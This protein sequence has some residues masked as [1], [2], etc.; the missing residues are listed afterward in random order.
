VLILDHREIVTAAHGA[1]QQINAFLD[2]ALDAAKL[3]AAVDPSLYRSR[4]T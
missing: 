3:A 2:N 4:G 1:A